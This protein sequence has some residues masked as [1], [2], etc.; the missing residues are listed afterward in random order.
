M[1]IHTYLS[2]TFVI[3]QT[4]SKILKHDFDFWN[5]RQIELG[6]PRGGLAKN[7]HKSRRSFSL[8]LFLFCQGVWGAE[9]GGVL[10]EWQA[11][12]KIVG[13]ALAIFNRNSRSLSLSLSC[14]LSLS[15]CLAGGFL[16]FFIFGLFLWRKSYFILTAD[17]QMSELK[18]KGK[19]RQAGSASGKVGESAKN[20]KKRKKQKTRWQ[21]HYAQFS[22]FNPSSSSSSPYLYSIASTHTYA[23]QS[24]DFLAFPHSLWFSP[25][26]LI[27][28]F[29]T[30]HTAWNFLNVILLSSRG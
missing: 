20:K 7:S 2:D 12:R 30:F 4:N 6:L 27:S 16:F 15:L 9:A 1:Y 11:S 14:S 19:Q 5:R 24:T 29:C 13:K 22:S 25:C 28:C 21:S 18:L 17:K 26:L 8:L 23:F 3:Y 10:G